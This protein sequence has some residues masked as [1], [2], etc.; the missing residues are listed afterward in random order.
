MDIAK[1][2]INELSDINFD[3]ELTK[4]GKKYT[5]IQLFFSKKNM[6]QDLI[7]QK[8]IPNTSQ[9]PLDKDSNHSMAIQLRAHGIKA[10]KANEL[11]SL[12]GNKAAEIGIKNLLTEIG[13]GRNIKNISGYL[14]TILENNAENVTS[15]DIKEQQEITNKSIKQESEK[16]E[17]NWKSIETHCSKNQLGIE[18]LYNLKAGSKLAFQED[19]EIYESLKLLLEMNPELIESKRPILGAYIN[20]AGINFDTL[21]NIASKFEIAN[22]AEKMLVFKKQLDIEKEKLINEHDAARKKL[23]GLD[24]EVLKNSMFEIM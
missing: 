1:K 6:D 23:I 12:Y 21:N 19:I 11:I 17:I 9:L 20:D 7:S 4:T 2:E 16:K 14:I 18:K 5:D 10:K 8:I 22:D 24:I 3:Y 15:A 13:N